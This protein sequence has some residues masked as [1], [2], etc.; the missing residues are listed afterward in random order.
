MGG[1]RE[2]IVGQGRS[3]NQLDVQCVPGGFGTVEGNARAD[4]LLELVGGNVEPEFDTL[5]KFATA[6]DS[7]GYVVLQLIPLTIDG[8]QRGT[9][10]RV[11]LL[12][13]MQG[14]AQV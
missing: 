8:S 9:G 10:E 2:P 1:L 3:I 14:V 5:G 7:P 11:V 6:F 13:L 12:N 4:D